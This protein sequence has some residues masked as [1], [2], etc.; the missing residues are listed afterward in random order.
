VKP[1][2]VRKAVNIDPEQVENAPS[3]GGSSIL[4][5]L[6][7]WSAAVSGKI[8]SVTSARPSSS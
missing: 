2:G 3:S 5:L 8:I 1:E 7:P 4:T 6:K